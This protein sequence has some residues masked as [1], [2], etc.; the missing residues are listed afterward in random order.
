MLFSVKFTLFSVK[1]TLFSIKITL[2][3]YKTLLIQMTMFHHADSL[4]DVVV[5]LG[6]LIDN[7]LIKAFINVRM[8]ICNSLP[9]VNICIWREKERERE[10]EESIG[11]ITCTGVKEKSVLLQDRTLTSPSSASIPL[12]YLFLR[13]Y[14][15][16]KGFLFLFGLPPL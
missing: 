15:R 7:T 1:I 12:E 14:I 3:L 2:F 16:I 8:Y 6:S 5:S 10:R 4:V 13:N 11:G 9:P